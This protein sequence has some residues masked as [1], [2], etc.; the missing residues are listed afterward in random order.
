MN[1]TGKEISKGA[2]CA[3]V[4]R[5][6]CGA[7]EPR[8]LFVKCR[9]TEKE[10]EDLHALMAKTGHKSEADFIRD[11]VFKVRPIVIR[12]ASPTDQEIWQQ[13]VALVNEFNRIGH[14]YNQV[15]VKVNTASL[16]MAQALEASSRTFAGLRETLRRASQELR[17]YLADPN[18]RL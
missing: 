1:R 2:R 10:R 5:H 6:T 12:T 7:R 17:D 3:D 18:K 9:V 15:V 4:A 16:P 8:R 13:M 11:A 14:N